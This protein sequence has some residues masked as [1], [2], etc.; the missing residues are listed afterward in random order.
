MQALDQIGEESKINLKHS[1]DKF[2]PFIIRCQ[3]ITM[4]RNNN[5]WLTVFT[6]L[7]FGV[8]LP[9]WLNTAQAYTIIGKV[10]SYQNIYHYRQG[11][12]LPKGRFQYHLQLR[13]RQCQIEFPD[14]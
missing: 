2:N 10:N 14:E 8:L 7:F 5:Q 11:Q 4:F 1:T 6:L 12:L 13:K 9:G 3:E